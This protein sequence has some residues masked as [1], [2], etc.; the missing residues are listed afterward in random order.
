MA[1]INIHKKYKTIEDLKKAINDLPYM[2]SDTDIR[3]HLGD[4]VPIVKYGDLD[5]MND[6]K[7][8]LPHNNSCCILLI[9]TKYNSGHFVAICRR[10]NLI[11]QFDSYGSTIDYELNFISKMMQNILG[12]EKRALTELIKTSDCDTIHNSTKYQS[13]KKIC[14]KESAICGRACIVF[15]EMMRMGFDLIEMK[16]WMDNLKEEYETHYDV[17]IPYDVVFSLLIK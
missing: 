12:M 3:R 1:F 7:Q 10:D 14:N 8:I 15:C 2:M 11:I 16:I 4:S 6:I 17:E 13:T 5:N 9:E